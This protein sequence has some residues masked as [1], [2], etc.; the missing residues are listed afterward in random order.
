MKNILTIWGK[1]KQGK[2]ETI[3]NLVPLFQA[4]YPNAK[5]NWLIEGD[6]IKLIIEVENKKIGIESQGDP[7]SRQAESLND[8]AKEEKCDLIIC[9]SRTRSETVHNIE[10]IAD[11]YD[12]EITWATNYRSASNQAT[13]NQMSAEHIFQLILTMI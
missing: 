8:F 11:Q 7:Y 3:K 1:E 2:S 6:D 12:Y 10:R 13:L 5:F 4:H 9:A